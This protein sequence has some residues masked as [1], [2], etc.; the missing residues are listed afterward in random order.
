MYFE[1]YGWQMVVMG[2]GKTLS[3]L[4][5]APTTITQGGNEVLHI[6]AC[7]FLKI[8]YPWA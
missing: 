5:W 2:Q 1:S 7:M 6:I 8:I 4:S 3:S